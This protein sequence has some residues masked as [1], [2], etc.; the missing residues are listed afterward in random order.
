[1]T[2][3]IR[4]EEA[5]KDTSP[6]SGNLAKGDSAPTLRNPFASSSTDQASAADFLGKVNSAPDS[7]AREGSSPVSDST[8]PVREESGKRRSSKEWGT[9]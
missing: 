1:M 6:H 7:E 9:Y 5:G 8:S 4:I 3:H 2:S